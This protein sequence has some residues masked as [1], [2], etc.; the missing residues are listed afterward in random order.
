MSDSGHLSSAERVLA[1]Q[2]ELERIGNAPMGSH[3]R[4]VTASTYDLAHTD[5]AKDHTP[6]AD[7]GLN[8]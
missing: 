5:T 8:R 4:L 6:A 3:R 7:Q 2:A 1:S